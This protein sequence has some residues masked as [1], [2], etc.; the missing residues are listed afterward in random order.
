MFSNPSTSVGCIGRFRICEFVIRIIIFFFH[1]SVETFE[2]YIEVDTLLGNNTLTKN[3]G[4]KGVG[5]YELQ[6]INPAL[7]ICDSNIHR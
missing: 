2:N 5:D 3:N 6:R 4:K 1:I 7:M